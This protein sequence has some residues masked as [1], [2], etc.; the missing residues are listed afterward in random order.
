[1]SRNRSRHRPQNPPSLRC[2]PRAVNLVRRKYSEICGRTDGA[3]WSLRLV[4][5]ATTTRFSCFVVTLIDH[6]FFQNLSGLLNSIETRMCVGCSEVW[7]RRTLCALSLQPDSPQRRP[8]PVRRR[9]PRSCS[10]SAA[11]GLARHASLCQ[12]RVPVT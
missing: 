5:R 11:P 8:R 1:M 2:A 10:S 3:L 12:P 7:E 4:G 9:A 6:V